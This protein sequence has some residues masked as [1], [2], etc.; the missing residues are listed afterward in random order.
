MPVPLLF[1]GAAAITGAVGGGK[2]IKAG[3]DQ[4]KAK[5]LNAEANQMVDEAANR[6]EYLRK[7]C[8]D[9]LNDLGQEKLFV[10]NGN[11]RKFL[12]AFE[13]IKN[14]DFRESLGII[15]VNKV[16]IDK[17][18]FEELGKMS[19]FALSLGQGGIA[20]IAGGAMT[21]FG[22][23]G[24]A[25]TFAAASTGTAIST[26]SGAAATNATLAFFGGGSLA[27]GGL[28]IAG[29][30]AVLG[31]LVAGPA[32]LVMGI[33]TGAKA[34]KNLENAKAN[35]A[36]AE[37]VVA[38]LRAGADQCVAIRRR[39]Y[40]FYSLLSRLDSRFLP[41]VDRLNQ[42]ITEEGVD[43]SMYSDESKKTVASAASIAVTIKTIIDTPILTDDG[44]ITVESRDVFNQVSSNKSICS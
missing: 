10:L 27:A 21:A 24:A 33:I 5:N 17:T 3:I 4:S 23:Y 30:T 22:A 31:G 14:V 40:M 12:D 2:T 38:Q 15:E 39:T 44:S 18:D 35:M 9:S 6:L 28:G 25:T 43:Y 16:H 34:G 13:Q 8:G 32:L 20:G 29:G 1:I 41:L 11:V 42:I 26:L 19:N 36:Q 7:Q 37:E